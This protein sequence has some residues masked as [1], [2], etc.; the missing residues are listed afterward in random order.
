M[1]LSCVERLWIHPPTAAFVGLRIASAR[2]S[3]G[4]ALAQS[5]WS[6]AL[7][8][9]QLIPRLWVGFFHQ[10]HAGSPRRGPCK[11]STLQSA[12]QRHC[13]QVRTVKSSRRPRYLCAQLPICA[14]RWKVA[15][16][17]TGAKPTGLSLIPLRGSPP[18]N[19][20]PQCWPLCRPPESKGL[21][22]C[23]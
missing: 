6:K 21:K 9:S 2:G 17:T 18:R 20:E 14:H 11:V 5:V 10:G 1:P 3:T 8:Q 13:R 16:T 23:S 22:T 12:C 15:K 19:L 7:A 4:A